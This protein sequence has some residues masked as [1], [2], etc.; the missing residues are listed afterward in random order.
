MTP[1]AAV[2]GWIRSPGHCANLMHSGYTE[3]AVSVA[4][5]ASSSL[6]VYWVQQFGTPL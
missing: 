2:G 1:D 5:D 4:V 6:G 3:M